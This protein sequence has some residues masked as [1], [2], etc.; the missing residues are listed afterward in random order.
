M[1]G[2]LSI[3]VSVNDSVESCPMHVWVVLVSYVSRHI[4]PL[5]CC[6][7]DVC[8]TYDFRIIHHVVCLKS[9]ISKFIQG[10][11]FTVVGQT[12]QLISANVFGSQF[13]G[14]GYAAQKGLHQSFKLGAATQWQSV[15]TYSQQI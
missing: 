2:T 11:F 13:A 10:I 15:N 6:M 1:F 7:H 4:V 8:I 12:K 3:Y 9:L 14:R 5:I